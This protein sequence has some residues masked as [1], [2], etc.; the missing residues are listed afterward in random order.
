MTLEVERFLSA[1]QDDRTCSPNTLNAYRSDLQQFVHFIGAQRDAREITR[2][3]VVAYLLWLK[4]RKY[5][6]TT[7]ARKIA[8]L[9]S[10][11]RFLVQAGQVEANPAEQLESPKVDKATPTVLSREEV[12]TLLAQPDGRTPESLRDK[13]ILELLYATGLRVSELVNLNVD[14][15]NVDTHT[16]RCSRR[17]LPIPLSESAAQAV[18][19]Y[20]TE[21]R[22]RLLRDSNERAL[23]VN[24][25]GDRLTRQG[26][27]LLIKTYARRA[28]IT[29]EVTPHTL[30]HSFATH[31]LRYEQKELK[32]IQMLL[33]HASI[34]TTQMY[35]HLS[36]EQLR[37]AYDDAHPRVLSAS[38]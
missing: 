22:P 12:Q 14:D 17:M 1:L 24:H 29:R 25:R 31:L 9:R 10:F 5:A 2:D 26:I 33:G 11:Y 20:L 30:R 21:A 32:A 34:S 3:D 8:A 23:L 6:P 35:R 7:V 36:T 37:Q 38:S 16:V 28:H 15:V 13:A 4:E 19:R 27:W 18:A